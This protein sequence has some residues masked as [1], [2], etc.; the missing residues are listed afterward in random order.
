MENK[1][2]YIIFTLAHYLEKQLN[3]SNSYEGSLFSILLP[4]LGHDSQLPRIEKD[5][6]PTRTEILQHTLSRGVPPLAETC[7]AHTAVL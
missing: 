4:A 5:Y 7:P 1:L 2:K 3:A 6:L